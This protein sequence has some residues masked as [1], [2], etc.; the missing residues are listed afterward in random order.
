LFPVRLV[1]LL[2]AAELPL[3]RLDPIQA[4]P[5]PAKQ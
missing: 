2:V 3:F 1:D 5:E 4:N